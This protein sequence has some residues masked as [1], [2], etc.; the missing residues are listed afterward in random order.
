MERVKDWID[1]FFEWV[2]AIEMWK[3]VKFIMTIIIMLGVFFSIW[4]ITT[5]T[6]LA[7]GF[8]LVLTIGTYWHDRREEEVTSVD[9]K[10]ALMFIEL[11]K[12]K[13]QLDISIRAIDVLNNRIDNLRD[14]LKI[15]SLADNIGE[16]SMIR[17]ADE[18]LEADDTAKHEWEIANED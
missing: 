17:I 13:D 8:F 10:K 7:T 14:A 5:H 12:M 4:F 9:S 18:T 2:M 15:I 6:L 16:E 11:M 3:K 1:S